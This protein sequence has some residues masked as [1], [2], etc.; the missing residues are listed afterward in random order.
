MKAMTHR[1]FHIGLLAAA[2]AAAGLSGCA[3]MT[4]KA[5]P[6][7]EIRGVQGRFQLGEIVDLHQAERV[8]F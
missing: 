8:D 2:L 4:P 1:L 7:A 5:P 3:S 6:M